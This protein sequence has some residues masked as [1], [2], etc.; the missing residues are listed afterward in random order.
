MFST[1][2]HQKLVPA[3]PWLPVPQ[4]ATPESEHLPKRQYSVV[5]RDVLAILAGH[6]TSVGALLVD[7]L[8]TPK[9]CQHTSNRTLR[10]ITA[11]RA[12]TLTIRLALEVVAVPATPAERE[13]LTPG[14]GPVVMPEY[15]DLS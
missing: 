12:S 2:R 10:H 1:A 11:S 5:A 15:R 6:P 14:G 8:A 7:V 13:L 4:K 9:R 3:D